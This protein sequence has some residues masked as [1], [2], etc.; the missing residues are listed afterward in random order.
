[1]L[2][3]LHFDT[4]LR[5]NRERLSRM[6]SRKWS[7][8]RHHS[9]HVERNHQCVPITTTFSRSRLRESKRLPQADVTQAAFPLCP[10]QPRA[11][12]RVVICLPARLCRCLGLCNSR[13]DLRSDLSICNLRMQVPVHRHHR[14]HSLPKILAGR[15]LRRYLNQLD[16]FQG[17][18][19]YFENVKREKVCLE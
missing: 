2:T 19:L 17:N 7:F 16:I 6:P 13:N 1:M 8:T 15:Y 3:W 10:V 18:K 9:Q 4:V 14:R 5:Y 11:F 12:T